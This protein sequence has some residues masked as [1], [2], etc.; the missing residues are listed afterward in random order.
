MK[1][2]IIS[3]THIKSS[4]E[5]LPEKLSEVF[6]N[7]DAIYHVGDLVDLSVVETLSQIAPVTAVSGNM[8]FPDTKNTLPRKHLIEV[9]GKKIGLFHGTGPPWGLRDRVTEEFLLEKPDVIIYGHSHIPEVFRSKNG[10]LYINP[11]SPTDRVFTNINSVAVMT[12]TKDT[13]EAELIY[14]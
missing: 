9:E 3:D 2:G 7:V 5:P 11:G 10:I 14:L 6:S 13:I 1:I 12:V 8:D 4:G